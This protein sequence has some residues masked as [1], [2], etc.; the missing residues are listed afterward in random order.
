MATSPQKSPSSPKSPTPKSPPS[1]KK[2]DSFLGKL[3]GTLARRKKAKEVS[4]G[5]TLTV[6]VGI[7]P[8]PDT[9]KPYPPFSDCTWT[10]IAP[11][12]YK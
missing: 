6:P 2:D 9:Q 12:G 7:S 11:V 1:R 10:M 8:A 5:G 3:G 4:C